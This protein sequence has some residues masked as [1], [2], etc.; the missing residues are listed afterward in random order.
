MADK[1]PLPVR[2]QQKGH[3]APRS[4]SA[5]AYQLPRGQRVIAYQEGQGYVAITS[6]SGEPLGYVDATAVRLDSRQ[7]LAAIDPSARRTSTSQS[8]SPPPGA[9][10]DPGSATLLSFLITGGGQL[11]AGQTGKGVGLLLVGTGAPI[12]GWAASESDTTCDSFG[13]TTET[14][15]TPLYVG[16]GVG[17]AAWLYGIATAGEDARI[18]NR[19]AGFSAQVRPA[20]VPSGDGAV[21]PG[22]RLTMQ[23]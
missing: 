10:N 19:A 15:F 16:A 6:E 11:Y 7:A 21:R 14:N 12:V 13:C 4:G 18:A 8:Q 20:A 22:V 5:V 17:L 9:Y 3:D 23:W 1:S 2:L